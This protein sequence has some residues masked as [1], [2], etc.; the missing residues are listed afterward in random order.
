[1]FDKEW[2]NNI[3]IKKDKVVVKIQHEDGSFRKSVIVPTDYY[4]LYSNDFKVFHAENCR[5]ISKEEGDFSQTVIDIFN[6]CGFSIGYCYT[7]AEMLKTRLC[8]AGFEAVQ[9][10]GWLFTD[11]T[12]I[13]VFHSWVVL[14]G[15]IVL[16]YSDFYTACFMYNSD[17]WKG[18]ADSVEV[19]SSF[20]KYVKQERIANALVCYPLGVPAIG[21]I[22]VGCPCGAEEG[23]ALW[24]NM[25]KKYPDHDSNRHGDTN[26]TDIQQRI[27]KDLSE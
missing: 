25:I 3:K 12:Q 13:P 1:M 9:Y 26:G 14:D 4:P 11:V 23:R 20:F 21:C 10:V 22:Y 7:N 5:N 17:V 8:K 2:I 15:N 6:K 27:W 19:L 18:R 24:R 16:D